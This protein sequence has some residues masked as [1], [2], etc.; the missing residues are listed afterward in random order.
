MTSKVTITSLLPT[1][2]SSVRAIYEEGIATG[3]ATF[4]TAAPDWPAWDANHRADCRLVAWL[5]GQLVGWAALSPISKRAVYSGVAEVSVY[6]AAA[7][8][9][10]GVGRTLLT[11]LIESSEAAGVWTLQAGIFP[12]NEASVSLHLSCGFRVVGRRER[13]GCHHSVWRDALLLERRSGV[14]GVEVDGENKPDR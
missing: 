2:W 14:V 8:Q 5:D 3:Q 4:E 1:D 13:L 10:R 7:A 12:E 6:V 11:G 9:G